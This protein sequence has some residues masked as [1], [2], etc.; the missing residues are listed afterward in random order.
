MDLGHFALGAL[1]V[2][3]AA[4]VLIRRRREWHIRID[5]REEPKNEPDR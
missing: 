1:V 5:Y 2:V 4:F 3:L